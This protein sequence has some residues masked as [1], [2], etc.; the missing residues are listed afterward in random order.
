MRAAL[1]MATAIAL[2]AAAAPAGPGAAD[3]A[4]IRAWLTRVYGSYHECVMR[5]AARNPIG[6]CAEPIAWLSV[7]TPDTQRLIRRDSPEGEATAANGADPICSCQDYGTF[8]VTAIRLAG[9][10]GGRVQARVSWNETFRSAPA[11]RHDRTLILQKTAAGWRVHDVQ[12]GSGTY[13]QAIIDEL[14]AA[15]RP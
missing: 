13:R 5:P 14:R 12:E 8:Q 11:A 6:Q 9:L 3:A 1:A 2:L 4:A 15:H 10:A 7:F